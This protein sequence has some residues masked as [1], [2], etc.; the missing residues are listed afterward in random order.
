MSR[1]QLAVEGAEMLGQAAAPL[2]CDFVARLQHARAVGDWPPRTSPAWR[3][4]SRVKQF[5]D[6]RALAV[7]PRRQDKP[8]ITPLHQMS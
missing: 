3:P 8:G 7:P 6:E 1:G 2:R 5:D 4:C